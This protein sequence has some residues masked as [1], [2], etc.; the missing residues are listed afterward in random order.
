[1]NEFS[2]CKGCVDD[3]RTDDLNDEMFCET[4]E[5]GK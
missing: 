2:T 5:K 4:C 3:F 1:M